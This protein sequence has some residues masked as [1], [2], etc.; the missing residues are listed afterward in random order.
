MCYTSIKVKHGSKFVIR[1][2]VLL[3]YLFASAFFIYGFENKT[4]ENYVSAYGSA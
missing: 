4:C 1:G 2:T 3:S